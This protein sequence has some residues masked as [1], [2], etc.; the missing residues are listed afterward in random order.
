MI[1]VRPIPTLDDSIARTRQDVHA[2]VDLAPALDSGVAGEHFLLNPLVFAP[3]YLL[4]LPLPTLGVSITLQVPVDA[5]PG[6]LAGEVILAG[7]GLAA[8]PLLCTGR[9][10]AVRVL[11]RFLCLIQPALGIIGNEIANTLAPV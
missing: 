2:G 10:A 11:V 9:P 6:L 4:I 5:H 7:A 8:G 1:F 3:G